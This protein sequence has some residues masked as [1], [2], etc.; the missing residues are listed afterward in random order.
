MFRERG[1]EI[2][3]PEQIAVMRRAGLVVGET[4]ELIRRTVR[5]GVTTGELDAVAEDH[6]RS[7][8]AT[9][10]VQGLPRL[11]GVVVPVGR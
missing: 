9:P 2:K 11:P 1:V 3:T 7:Q 10:V 6:I 5:P 4:L 8:G